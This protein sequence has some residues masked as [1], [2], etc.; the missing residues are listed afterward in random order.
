LKDQWRIRWLAALGPV[1]V[2][3]KQ[4][5]SFALWPQSG[6]DGERPFHGFLLGSMVWHAQFAKE[7]V[8]TLRLLVVK[9]PWVEEFKS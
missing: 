8:W 2:G 1:L 4:N 3:P 6:K 5:N 9:A 7:L